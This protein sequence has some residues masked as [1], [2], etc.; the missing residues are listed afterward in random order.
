M[1]WADLLSAY[2]Q[3]KAADKASDQKPQYSIS[4]QMDELFQRMMGLVDYSPTRDYISTYADGFIKSQNAP[5]GAL[6][7]KPTYQSDYMKNQP[8][9]PNT[10]MDL[11]KLA[12]GIFNGDKNGLMPWNAGF[13]GPG[14]GGAP[15][16]PGGG[17]GGGGSKGA[18]Q[19][20]GSY[21]PIAPG[22]FNRDYTKQFGNMGGGARNNTIDGNDN[23]GTIRG[24][25]GPRPGAT[26]NLPPSFVDK[27]IDEGIVQ[28]ISQ[29]GNLLLQVGGAIIGFAIMGPTGIPAGWKLTA[30]GVDWYT[31]HFGSPPPSG[32]AGAGAGAGN[33]GGNG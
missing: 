31:K 23:P 5:G 15:N 10:A 30:Q 14:I 1:N 17:S 12:G 9:L 16:V 32:A 33:A 7:W 29:N 6:S 22:Y 18:L 11:S 13:T 3:Y 21:G 19:P 26:T 20:D 28:K 8:P 25:P 27:W 2:L 4:P 24:I